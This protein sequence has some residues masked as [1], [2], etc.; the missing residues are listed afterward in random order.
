MRTT[1]SSMITIT[2]TV[3]T[4]KPRDEVFAYVADFTTAAEWDPGV[5]ASNRTSGDGGVGTTY[6]VTAS[7]RGRTVP[8]TYEVLDHRPLERIV[9]RGV[10]S[11]TEAVDTIEF[12]DEAGGTKVSYRAEFTMKGL[13]RLAEPFMGG[14]FEALGITALDGMAEALGGRR[15]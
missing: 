3:I 14:M 9:L 11:T 7:F 2:E 13:M 6:S 8:M 1:L 10:G 4:P 12:F 15:V 5:V